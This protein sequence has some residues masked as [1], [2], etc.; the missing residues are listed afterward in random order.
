MER[1]AGIG[2][3]GLIRAFDPCDDGLLAVRVHFFNQN[4]SFNGFNALLDDN[5]VT[6]GNYTL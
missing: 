6:S 3:S 4:G 5:L 2:M 1:Q